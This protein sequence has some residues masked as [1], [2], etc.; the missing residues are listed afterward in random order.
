HPPENGPQAVSFVRLPLLQGTDALRGAVDVHAHLAKL[1]Q[2]MQHQLR[3]LL[4]LRELLHSASD[5]PPWLK[6]FAAE[7]PSR[8]SRHGHGDDQECPCHQHAAARRTSY[9]RLS[10]QSLLR[11]LQQFPQASRLNEERFDRRGL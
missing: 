4:A 3:I 9:L 7:P 8:E 10:M 6:A 1:A 5:S 2:P 11:G